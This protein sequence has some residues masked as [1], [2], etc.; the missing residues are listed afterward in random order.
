[1]KK[2]GG[3]SMK[4]QLIVNS[5]FSLSAMVSVLIMAF[6][7][8]SPFA[9]AQSVVGE[10][11]QPG[12]AAELQVFRVDVDK[13]GKE[14]FVPGKEIKP[15]ETLEYRTTYLNQGKEGVTNLQAKLPIPIGMEYLP[16]SAKP[17]D[18]KASLD[19]S[20]YEAVPLKRKIRLPD[21]SEKEVEVPYHEYRYLLWEV[22]ALEGQKAVTTRARV[23][24]SPLAGQT[25]IV[26][27][28][29]NSEKEKK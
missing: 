13:K 19:G 18:V 25:P 26:G 16:L 11:A 4:R 15:G 1:M 5:C 22:S 6:L 21:G 20:K 17:A 24:L 2:K 14:S 8:F 9:S 3:V 29:G 12:V 10:V 7:F 27:S 23:R 28:L